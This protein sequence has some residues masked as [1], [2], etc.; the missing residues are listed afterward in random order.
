[1]AALDVCRLEDPMERDV[2]ALV[3]GKVNVCQQCPLA[4]KGPPVP[5]GA[6]GP[7]LPAGEGGVVPFCC[8]I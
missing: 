1:M 3:D 6:P 7:A 4:V 2:E 8:F 5:W